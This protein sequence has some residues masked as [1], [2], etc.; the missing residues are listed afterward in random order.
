MNQLFI[1]AFEG[2]S[3]ASLREQIER[4]YEQRPSPDIE[5][6]IAYSGGEFYEQWEFFLIRDRQGNLFEVNS[7]HC[8]CYG[9]EGQWEPEP[10]TIEYLKSD[11]FH[12]TGIDDFKTEVKN[13][14]Q[15]L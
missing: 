7:S 14:I 12:F 9:F 4:E 2:F 5:M 11:K 10:T 1:G 15:S 3:D 13:F 6:L 8:S